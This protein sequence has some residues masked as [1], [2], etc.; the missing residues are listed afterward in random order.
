[1][2]CRDCGAPMV[3]ITN[4][5]T[6]RRIPCDPHPDRRGNVAATLAPAGGLTGRVLTKAA[7]API[8]E[9]RLYMPHKAT[10]AAARRPVNKRPNPPPAL[11]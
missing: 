7:P 1:M 2:K 5:A 8:G 4:T 10:C 6:G 11:F 9:E 3:F